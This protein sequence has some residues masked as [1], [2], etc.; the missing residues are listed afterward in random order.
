[1]QLPLYYVQISLYDVVV[2]LY[3]VLVI[4]YHVVR[5]TSLYDVETSLYD[6]LSSS[7]WSMNMITIRMITVYVITDSDL[8][9]QNWYKPGSNLRLFKKRKTLTCLFLD[10]R[11]K[12]S[13]QILMENCQIMNFNR[14]VYNNEYT[15]S[16]IMSIQLTYYVLEKHL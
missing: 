10:L 11:W 5:F 15:G 9:L 7:L 4:L 8:L 2:S 6:V 12:K 3:Y 1:M 14:W 16:T 13:H